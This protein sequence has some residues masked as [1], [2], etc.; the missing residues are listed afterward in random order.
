M[1]IKTLDINREI[2]TII[3]D[4]LL[5]FQRKSQKNKSMKRKRTDDNG[6][7]DVDD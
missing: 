2:E 3:Y 7:D 4:F 5:N 1:V 6:L